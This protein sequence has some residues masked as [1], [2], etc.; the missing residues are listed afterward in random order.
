MSTPNG[1]METVA[2]PGASAGAP[3]PLLRAEPASALRWLRACLALYIS[4]ARELRRDPMALFW[5]AF[6]PILFIV[7]YGVLLRGPSGPT[8][9]LG[10]VAASHGLVAG[11]IERQLQAVK[12][13]QVTR[14]DRAT[15]LASMRRGNLDGVVGL[16]DTLDAALHGGRASLTVT[17]DPAHQNMAAIL[18]SLAAQVADRVDR[19]VTGRRQML[20]VAA[21]PLD[22]R[23]LD[24][25]AYALPGII[26]MALIQ[27]GVMGTSLPLI[28]L[29]Q[30]GVLRQLSATPLRRGVLA[31]SQIALRLTIA[32]AQVVAI[33]LLGHYV[34][35]VAMIGSWLALVLVA[36][37]G[38]LVMIALG[39]LL[40]ARARTTESGNGITT[41]AFLPL[42]FLSGLFFPLELGPTW[43][44][45]ASAFVPSTYLGDALRQIMVGATPQFSLAIDL[46]AMAAFLL[47]ITAAATRL[48]QWE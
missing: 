11:R 38:A 16:P 21:E 34:L 4:G 8:V 41:A 9:R 12:G 31:T 26:A 33:A 48:F 28:S 19:Q 29:R 14:G 3:R 27:V 10:V 13:V 46:A 30:N 6:L 20:Y 43:M 35:G 24:A 47:V 39:Y 36:T 40:A 37:L 45:A 32:L 15:L 2:A 22:G 7:L 23:V 44:K 5:M 25:F 17:Y 1:V 42:V 18:Q